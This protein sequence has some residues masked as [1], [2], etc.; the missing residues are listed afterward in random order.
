MTA[1]RPDDV[2]Q[3]AQ[4]L[5][6]PQDGHSFRR[7]SRLV[8]A[9]RGHLAKA[10]PPR[11]YKPLSQDEI[12]DE[13]WP[14]YLEL[15]PSQTLVSKG[16]ATFVFTFEGR[17]VFFGLVAPLLREAWEVTGPWRRGSKPRYVRQG[18]H[19]RLRR[20]LGGEEVYSLDVMGARPIL[21]TMLAL[22]D[23]A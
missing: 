22:I 9:L 11:P 3:L 21:E 8:E 16:N 1:V 14:T 23:D 13:L 6:S 7:C 17:R 19:E 5:E 20:A 18:P 12:D 15:F 2:R 10:G 4:S